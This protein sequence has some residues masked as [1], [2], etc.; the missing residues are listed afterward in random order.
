M[1][2]WQLPFVRPA[3]LAD[4][5]FSTVIVGA[6][7]N[8]VGVFRDLSLQ[9]VDCLIVDK[10]DFGA[11]ASSAPSRMIHGGLRYLE[12]GS[13]SLV[14]EATRER[15]LLLRN[16][17]HLVRPLKTVVPL[18]NF[19][20]GLMSS[21]LKFFGRTPPQRTRGLLAVALGLRLYDILGRRQRVM[22]GHR[23]SRVPT[24]DRSLFRA[25]IRWTAT[26]FDAWIS[27]PEW[28]ILELIGDACRDQPRSAAANYCRVMGC[29]GNILTLR[30]ELTGALV[31][32]TAD[33][34][35][36]A[37]GAWLD[38]SA[39]VLGGAGPRVMGTKGSHLVLDHP[40]LR[41]ALDG[42]MAYFEAV[43]G[44]VCIVYP[45]LD[46]VLVGST[47]I[48]VED[49]DQIV[50]EP[51]EVDYLIDVLREVF[52]NMAFGRDHVVYTYVGVRPLARSD[53]DKPGQISRDHS[54]VVDPPSA[55]RDIPIVGLVGGKWTTFRSLAEEATTEVLQLLGRSRTASTEL[56]P[57]GG[58]ADLPADAA[59][60]ERFIEKM[61]ASGMGRAR[62]L[63]L[64]ARYGSKALPLAQRLAAS[65]DV[66][67]QHAPDYSAAEL[68]YLCLETGVVHL[69]DLVIR[70][71]LLAIRGLVTD[72]ALAEISGIAAEALGWDAARAHKELRTCA[73]ALREHHN[74]RL[75]AVAPDVAPSFDASLMASSALGQS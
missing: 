15:N 19:F 75:Q 21:A 40:A 37:T 56:L 46:R 18:A 29:A 52:P 16:A 17:P 62:A 47:D 71:T 3:S 32:V 30:D 61:T 49:P 39:A 73:T 51:A 70:R 26:F 74:V 24:N 50:T 64:L 31:R 41:D 25:A 68:S 28:L 1:S 69:D 22:P 13:F 54:V 9:R 45:F 66:P 8:G 12:N 5:H 63:T 42:R 38:R 14:A 55:T 72:A 36:N 44:R 23:I 59:A 53:A 2:A 27:H 57:I 60:T 34:V 33:T 11:G 10:G 65:G 35:V 20:G 58:G 67:L 48:P 43:D 7:I 6:G 4:R